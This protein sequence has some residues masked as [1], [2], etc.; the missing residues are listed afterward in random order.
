MEGIPLHKTSTSLAAMLRSIV[1]IMEPHATGVGIKLR[2]VLDAG[3]PA[4]VLV[5]ED[6]IAWAVGTLVG[7]ALRHVPRGSSHHLGGT[8]TVHA[9]SKPETSTII[10]EVSDDGPGI[11]PDKLPLLFQPAPYQRRV[12]YALI[13]AREIALAHGGNLEVEST[14]DTLTHGTTVRLELPTH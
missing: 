11:P 3:L 6:K 9:A 4:T 7:N 5:D 10:I 14:Q 8:I 2:K 1:D 13:L 12:G